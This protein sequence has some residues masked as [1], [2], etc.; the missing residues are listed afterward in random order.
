MTSFF[1]RI[2]SCSLILSSVAVALPTSAATPNAGQLI[3][4][5]CPA[6]ADVN[7]PCKAVYFVGGDSKRHAFPN[8][9]TYFTWFADFSQIKTVTSASLASLPLGA[10]VNYRPGIKLVKF[11]TV[12]KVYAVGVGGEL[13]WITTEAAASSL[14]G[15]TWN[16]Q[17]DDISDAFFLD[18]RIGADIVSAADFNRTAETADALTPDANLPSTSKT[19]S[20][21]TDRG[22]FTADVIMLQKGRFKMV[23]DTANTADCSNG[24]AAKSLGEFVSSRMAAAGIH[25]TYFCPPEYADC[26]SKT[27][28]F[29]APVYNSTAGAMINAS[30]LVVHEGPILATATDGRTFF[31]HRTKDFGS[32]VANFQTKNGATLAAAISNYPSLVEHGQVVVETENRLLETNPGTKSLRGG[33]GIN[34]HFFFLVIVHNANVS[35]LASVM[36]TL[37]ATDALNLDGGGSSALW[38]NGS[39]VVGPGRPIPNAVL[40]VPTL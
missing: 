35:D 17:V 16:K 39:Y 31:S 15:A 20:V 4:L 19:I 24:C 18:Y 7:D 32:S 2:A 29:L 12:D 13:R 38:Y 6:N 40:F 14:Y 22:T 11:T 34:G 3:K 23:T 21:T 10:N 1:R 36:K 37:G 26:A 33:I 25:G 30:S 8:D 5:N 28:T 27:N 9:K